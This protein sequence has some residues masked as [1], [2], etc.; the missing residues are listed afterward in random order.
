MSNPVLIAI[1][2][3][4]APTLTGLLAIAVVILEHRKT[5]TEIHTVGAR[6]ND[7][8]VALDGKLHELIDVTSKLAHRE[9]HDEGWADHKAS[10]E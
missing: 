2:G 3:S 9:G 8:E 10:E 1:V 4:V 5:K 6:V 7:V